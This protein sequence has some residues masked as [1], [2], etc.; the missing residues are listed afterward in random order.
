MIYDLRN[1]FM[2]GNSVN[3]RLL[4]V[5]KSR[6][7]LIEFAGIIYRLGLTAS[8]DLS[9]KRNVPRSDNHDEFAQKAYPQA[10]GAPKCGDIGHGAI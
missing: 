2:H 8:L 9:W 1:D 3:S 4:L 5:R 10:S 6:R 7:R